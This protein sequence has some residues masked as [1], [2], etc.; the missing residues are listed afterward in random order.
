MHLAQ[1]TPLRS[2]PEYPQLEPLFGGF[3][4]TPIMV[5]NNPESLSR[6]GLLCASEPVRPSRAGL[7][8]R[9]LVG[10]PPSL[11]RF[12]FYMHHIVKGDLRDVRF[13]LLIMSA[14]AGVEAEF[15][16]YGAAVSL[17]SSWN[18]GETPSFRV[19]QACLTGRLWREG[20]REQFIKIAGWRVGSDAPIAVFN[21]HAGQGFSAD[22]RVHI[23]STNGVPLRARVVAAPGSADAAEAWAFAEQQYAY[24]NIQC[25]CC[26][27]ANVRGTRGGNGW[28]T[29]CGIYQSDKWSGIT[30]TSVSV[31][32]TIRGWKFLAAPGNTYDEPSAPRNVDASGNLAGPPFGR[33]RP[34]SN[35]PVGGDNQRP[36]AI[37]YYASSPNVDPN[38]RHSQNG[39]PCEGRDSDA[40]STSCY[41]GE[42]DLS[43]RVRND[44][45]GCVHV[46]LTFASYPGTNPPWKPWSATTRA[47]DGMM[48]FYL[49][50]PIRSIG[51]DA[52]TL[53]G[54]RLY[55]GQ[56]THVINKPGSLAFELGGF[57]LQ[58]GETKDMRLRLMVPG[59]VVAPHG[60]V[61]HTQPC[62]RN[63]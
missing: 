21:L 31:P 3:N 32:R 26:R 25:P 57:R 39:F 27:G 2:F 49:K 60:F 52:E 6:L 5:S 41:G 22:A 53:E 40:F 28:G 8:A 54:W 34:S 15:N 47:W 55:N 4:R 63:A 45:G 19:E 20:A 37:A 46:R 10:T 36:A 62:Q 42:F 12:S 56:Y 35:L 16:A 48:A 59:L 44:T 38:A 7:Y 51:Q 24:G 30:V 13:M 23:A 14:R 43:W 33:C 11:T 61:L 1:A 58:V 9:T 50:D 18:I 17:G 29:P